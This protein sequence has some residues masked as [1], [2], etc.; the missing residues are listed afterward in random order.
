MNQEDASEFQMYLN[1]YLEETIKGTSEEAQFKHLFFGEKE[2]V[3]K[4]SHVNYESATKESFTNLSV[5]LQESNTLEEALRSL[6]RAEDLTGEN[7]YNHEQ[8]GKQDA[9]KFM[10]IKTMPAVL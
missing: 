7:Q 9:K 1:D 4:C 5:H 8:Y 6:F 2:N 10:R 3:I